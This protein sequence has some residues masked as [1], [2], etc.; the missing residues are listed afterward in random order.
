MLVEFQCA[1]CKKTVQAEPD[2]E[3]EIVRYAAGAPRSIWYLLTC[4]E[5][6]TINEVKVPIN[7]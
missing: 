2:A 3:D 4:P 6:K 1:A 7:E 5:C